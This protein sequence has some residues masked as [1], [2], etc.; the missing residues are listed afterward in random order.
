MPSASFPGAQSKITGEGIN[1]TEINKNLVRQALQKA[2]GN[3]TRAAKL[4]GISRSSLLYR[5]KNV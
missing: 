4:L 5:L 1:L 3:K 2:G